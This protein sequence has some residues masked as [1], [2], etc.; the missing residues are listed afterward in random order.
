[1]ENIAVKNK[2]VVEGIVTFMLYTT[3]WADENATEEEIKKRLSEEAFQ[4]LCSGE[5]EKIKPY[6]VEIT[7][8]R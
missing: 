3:T 5:A 1:M 7:N 4:D 2:K 6:K 8:T